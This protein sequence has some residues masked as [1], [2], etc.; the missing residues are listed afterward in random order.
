M[1]TNNVVNLENINYIELEI[2]DIVES[3][4][5][6]MDIEVENDHYYTLSNGIVS[7]N[8][9][10]ILTQ[11]TSGIEPAFMIAYKRR[12]KINPNDKNL[13]S[14][15][16]DKNGDHW[17]EYSVSHPKFNEWLKVNNYDLE[18]TLSLP[19][20]ELEKIIKL[21][22]YYGATSDVIDWVEKVRMQGEMQKWVDHSISV[23][24]NLP[25]NTTEEMVS[26]VYQMAWESGC[27][28]CTVYRDGSRDGVLI[29][30]KDKKEI[31]KI[32]MPIGIPFNAETPNEIAVSIVAKLIDVRNNLLK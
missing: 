21:S 29:S 20:D 24:V 4:N 23:T 26:K 22:P 31:E 2:I 9:V 27:K 32:N 15:F 12:K 30:D 17:E 13:K 8:T 11:T 1:M 18:K 16:I 28:G 10:S 6:T 25:K 3:T 7:H 5:E 14:S 19:D